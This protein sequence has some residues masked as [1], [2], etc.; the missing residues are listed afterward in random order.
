MCLYNFQGPIISAK[1]ALPQ[2]NILDEIQI[3]MFKSYYKKK[4]IIKVKLS[5]FKH[6]NKIKGKIKT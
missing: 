2:I 4:L 6:F 1:L 5:F 3:A